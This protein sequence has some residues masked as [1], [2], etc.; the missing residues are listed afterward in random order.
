MGLLGAPAVVSWYPGFLQ[1]QRRYLYLPGAPG[2]QEGHE[3]STSMIK[4]GK[5]I[6]YS[7]TGLGGR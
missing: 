6:R 4:A 5:Y 1:K 3:Q 2:W 7:D